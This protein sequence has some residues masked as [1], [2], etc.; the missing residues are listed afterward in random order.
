M[1]KRFTVA[2]I[3]IDIATKL[4]F[5]TFQLIFYVWFAGAENQKITIAM[6]LIDR[7]TDALGQQVGG[8]FTVIIFCNKI[9]C[10]GVP[11]ISVNTIQYTSA[12]SFFVLKQALQTI[13]HVI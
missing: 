12:F 7:R 1:A 6:M 13:G 9:I 5:Y 3:R 11:Y 4:V 8:F 10:I 2:D